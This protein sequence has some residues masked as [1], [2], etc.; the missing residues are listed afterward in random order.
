LTLEKYRR[1][2]DIVC[3]D[4]GVN[5]YTRLHL[6]G[7]LVFLRENFSTTAKLRLFYSP[8]NRGEGMFQPLVFD[9]DSYDAK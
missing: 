2:F 8:S 9:M 6:H 5:R 1:R 7:Q 3:V 4:T